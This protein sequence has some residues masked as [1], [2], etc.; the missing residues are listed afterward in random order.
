VQATRQVQPYVSNPKAEVPRLQSELIDDCL[1][2]QATMAAAQVMRSQIDVPQMRAIA[3]FL[4]RGDYQKVSNNFS[5][6]RTLMMLECLPAFVRLNHGE[7]ALGTRFDHDGKACDVDKTTVTVDGQPRLLLQE[8]LLF[9]LFPKERVVISADHRKFPDGEQNTIAVR[10]NRDSLD[11]RRRWEQFTQE[12]NY[13]RGRSFFADGEI[14]E[15]GKCW[16]WDDILLSQAVKR[17]IQTHVQDFLANR[18]RLRNLG[19]KCRRGL[20]L[21]GAPGT[22]KTLLGKVLS[23]ILDV[24]FMW[25]LPRHIVNQKSFQEILSV[26]RYVAPTVVFLEDLDLFAEE[27]EGNK[28]LGLGELMNQLDGVQDNDDIVT[29][30]TTNRLEV[31]EKALRN[32]PGRFDRIVEIGP[33]DEPCRRQMFARLLSR[34]TI[35]EDEMARLIDATAGYTGAQIQELT[36]T[37]YILAVGDDNTASSLGEDQSSLTVTRQLIDRA[38]EEFRVE[39]KAALGFHVG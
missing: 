23:S 31:V 36:N 1:S 18:Q 26:A 20:I 7:I 4:E 15:Q 9:I 14:I 5:R 25:V 30:A 32:R 6:L 16:T 24:S 21:S 33:M 37:I 12:H 17:S 2:A 35:R 19:V 29:I 8:G 38:V 39:R 22:G 27:R 13:L 28:W 10:S 11:F 34:S 3:I